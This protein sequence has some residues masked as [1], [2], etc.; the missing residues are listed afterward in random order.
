MAD[1]KR[2][3]AGAR[4]HDEIM[5]LHESGVTSLAGIGR[6]VGLSGATVKR[7][8]RSEGIDTPGRGEARKIDAAMVDQMIGEYGRGDSYAAIGRR[9]GVSATSVSN[10]LRASGM[11]TERRGHAN[12]LPEEKVAG[13][14]ELGRQGMGAREVSERIGVSV[15]TAKKYLRLTRA[16]STSLTDGEIER[17]R[18]MREGGAMVSDVASEFG[19]SES[20]V[21]THTRGT[22]AS[23]RRLDDG[24]VSD[25]RRLRADG[26]PVHEIARAFGVSTQTVRN[27]TGDVEVTGDGTHTDVRLPEARRGRREDETD[28]RIREMCADGMTASEIA[29]EIGRTPATVLRHARALGVMPRRGNANA[30][31]T[32]VI[33]QMRDMRRSGAPIR[34]IAERFGVSSNTAGRHVR[35]VSVPGRGGTRAT[36]QETIDRMVSMARDGMSVSGIAEATGASASTVSRYTRDVRGELGQTGRGRRGLPEG[37]TSRIAAMFE[38]GMPVRAIAEE[39]GV[40]AATVRNRLSGN[41]LW[42]ERKR[43]HDV[44][45]AQEAQMRELI[46][47]GVP[48]SDV[49]ARFGVSE[50]TVRNHTAGVRQ[51][52]GTLSPERLEAMAKARRAGCTVAECAEIGSVSVNTASR[53]LRGIVPDKPVRRGRKSGRG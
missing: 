51:P 46:G 22:S 20:T 53:R 26:Y 35:D 11:V 44:G 28:A 42:E 15:A 18:E 12:A 30:L 10:Y 40:S 7:V 49:A 48:V 23:R 43:R 19:V 14:A 47:Q 39:I 1:G 52:R 24:Q 33:R 6:I 27:H 31:P 34:E 8:L 4:K 45:G 13:I 21:I 29:A 37:A 9:H 50:T 5:R 16:A 36:P 38:S 2:N 3:T 17:M 25:I 41:P 32:E